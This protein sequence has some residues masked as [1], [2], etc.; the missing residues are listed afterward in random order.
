MLTGLFALSQLYVIPA[1]AEQRSRNSLRRLTFA[2]MCQ[3]TRSPTLIRTHFSSALHSASCIYPTLGA[4]ESRWRV[5][6]AACSRSFSHRTRSACVYNRDMSFNNLTDID[7]D[8]FA[9]LIELTELSV[10]YSV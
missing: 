1:L 2:G 10:S 4:N 6:C 9:S 7:V 3:A 8:T 5:V